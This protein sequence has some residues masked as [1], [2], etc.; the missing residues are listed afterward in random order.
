LK[1]S[2]K[3]STRGSDFKNTENY[4][5]QKKKIVEEIIASIKLKKEN[6]KSRKRNRPVQEK[7]QGKN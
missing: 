5:K 7:G 4:S 1:F 6:F 2:F 3:Y